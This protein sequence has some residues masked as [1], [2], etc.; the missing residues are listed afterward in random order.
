MIHSLDIV[1]FRCFKQLS[2]DRC[3]RF[4]VIVGENGA[5]KTSLL[6]AIFMALAATQI[7]P[8]DIVANAVSAALSTR[9][10]YES[11]KRFSAIFSTNG[12]GIIQF[13]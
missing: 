5:G 4:N 1:N 8:S 2:T 7:S 12:S 3:R 13:T 11:K 9:P 6:E 10:H